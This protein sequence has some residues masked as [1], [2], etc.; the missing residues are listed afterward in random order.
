MK[1]YTR[2]EFEDLAAGYA[3]G[4][5]SPEETDAVEQ[6]LTESP[7]FA[8]DLRAYHE[9]AVRMAQQ[10]AVAPPPQLRDQFLDRIRDT[11]TVPFPAPSTPVAAVPRTTAPDRRA[12]STW[13]AMGLAASLLVAAALGYQNLTLRRTLAERGVQL[14]TTEGQLAHREATLDA[15]L[16]AERDLYVVQMTS[17]DTVAGPGIQFFWN[18]K[19]QKGVAHAFR[20][21]PAPAGKSYQLWL[22]RNGKPESVKV[23]NSDPDGHALVEGLTLPSSVQGVTQ[24]LLTL[25]PAGGSAQPTSTPFVG[26]TLVKG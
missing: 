14:V 5:T 2:E 7:E 16:E 4:A 25:E 19:Q 12:T 22:I 18:E 23:F 1:R 17:A 13:M 9:L 15:L 6:M 3:L 10:R 20:L 21:K 26:G 24:V 11:K 8:S